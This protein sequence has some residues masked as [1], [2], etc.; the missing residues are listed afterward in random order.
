[1]L[2]NGSGGESIYNGKKFKDERAGLQL[3]HERGTL[4][5]G[6]SGKNSNSSQ[7]FFPFQAAPQCDGKHVVFGRIVSGLD[8]LD[9]AEKYGTTEGDPTAPICITDCGVFAPFHV[10]GAG[11]WYDQPDEDSFSGVSPV[12]MV[13]PRVA[14]LAPNAAVKEKFQKAMGDKAIV[15]CIS[16]EDLPEESM[17]IDRIHELL[18]TFAV[19]VVVVAPVCKDITSKITL[20]KSWSDA[21]ISIVEVVLESKPIEALSVVKTKSWLSKKEWLLE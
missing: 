17:Q 13:L 8:V 10:P 20:P 18:G 21:G 19:D 16:A 12:F 9:A 6:N 1:M 4:S 7:F 14:V 15:T 3:K 2:G 5:M 11:Y